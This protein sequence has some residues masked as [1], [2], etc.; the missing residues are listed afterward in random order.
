MGV[1]ENKR[2]MQEL[3]K[4][5][6]YSLEG[7]N[8]EQRKKL[9]NK[10]H[11]HIEDLRNY[12]YIYYGTCWWCYGNGSRKTTAKAIDLFKQENK[13]IMKELD[14]KEIYYVG[15]L[16]ANQLEELTTK[17]NVSKD[18][19]DDNCIGFSKTYHEWWYVGKIEDF[20]NPRAVINA[21]TLFKQ[22][23][24]KGQIWEHVKTGERVEVEKLEDGYVYLN[25]GRTA[26]Y[27][28]FLMFWELVEEET[29]ISPHYNNDKG[30]LYQFC[31]DKQLNSYEFDIIKRVMRCR[32]KGQF[33]EDLEKTKFLIDLYIKE[34]HEQSK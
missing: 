34:H 1:R 29:T 18:G 24:K 32:K 27:H 14:K 31:E 20:T 28:S 33:I 12:N 10:S 6:V 3:D 17:Y 2:V 15:D 5:E 9:S 13:I 25:I 30:S 16:T 19:L 8:D 7:L 11:I 21:T 4:K 23:I 26:N 22:E